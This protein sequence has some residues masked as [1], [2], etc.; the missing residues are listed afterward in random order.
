[1]AQAKDGVVGHKDLGEN[2]YCN[3]EKSPTGA[4]GLD[5]VTAV[6]RAMDNTAY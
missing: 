2:R 1:L 3:A 6:S 5:C 4:F